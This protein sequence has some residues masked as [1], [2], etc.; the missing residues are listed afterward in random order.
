MKYL[1]KYLRK[2]EN[3]E[4]QRVFT[5]F[6][7]VCSDATIYFFWV[8]FLRNSNVCLEVDGDDIDLIS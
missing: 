4:I 2:A 1:L 6:S 7:S 3:F 8:Q 5:A